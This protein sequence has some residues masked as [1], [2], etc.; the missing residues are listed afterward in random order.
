MTTT[1]TSPLFQTVSDKDY[2]S[3]FNGDQTNYEGV[4]KRLDLKRDDV[5]RATGVPSASVRYDGKIP[6]DVSQRITEWA[7]LL[8][9][10]AQHFEGDINKTSLWFTSL[11]PLLGNFSPRDMI[12]M[13]RYKKLIKF[14]VNALLENSR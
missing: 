1:Q 5:A 12:R 2:F 7:I 4:I 11:N 3:L 8:N 9:L 6:K 14:V 10:V 13:G